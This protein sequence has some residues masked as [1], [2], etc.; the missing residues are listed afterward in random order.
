MRTDAAVMMSTWR[1]ST[2]PDKAEM[3][4]LSE[5]RQS[6]EI[7]S[8]PFLLLSRGGNVRLSKVIMETNDKD[9]ILQKAI[10]IMNLYAMSMHLIVMLLRSGKFLQSLRH[11]QWRAEVAAEIRSIQPLMKFV[12]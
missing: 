3:L 8:Y 6:F 12:S 2:I 11:T 5:E 9:I 1:T 7:V 4:R 10:I